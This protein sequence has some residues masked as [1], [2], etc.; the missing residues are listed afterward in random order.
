MTGR[1]KLLE[2]VLRGS[3]DANIEFGPL[4]D[5]L[6]HLGFRERIRGDHHIFSR[7]GVAEILNLQP[8]GHHAKSYQVKQVRIVII[9]YK[10]GGEIDAK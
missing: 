3:S 10:L 4:C 2:L 1:E 5:L 7:D 9:H 6:R 8:L